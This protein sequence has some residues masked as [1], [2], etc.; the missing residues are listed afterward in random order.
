M[1]RLLVVSIV[2]TTLTGTS[3]GYAQVPERMTYQGV[4]SDAAGE[5][6]SMSMPMT[7]RIYGQA[8]GG[9]PLWAETVDVEVA[10]GLFAAELG[11]TTP[12]PAGIF[13]ADG[14]R[15]LGLEID[16]DGEMVPR[17][18]LDSVPYALHAAAADKVT[19]GTADVTSVSVS[20]VPVI[21]TQGNWVGPI[22][23]LG[24]Q[25]K[26][27]GCATGQAAAYD[28]HAW[29]CAA[30]GGGAPLW[31]D[32]IGK[33]T[34]LGDLTCAADGDIATWNSAIADWECVPVPLS[35]LDLA[36]HTGTLG[37]AHGGT[38]L[39]SG[40]AGGLVYF[41]NSSTMAA[42]AA[43]TA[44]ALLLGAGAGAGPTVLP[45]GAANY[46]VGMNS[47]GTQN[48]YKQLG[49]QNGIS[50][51]NAAGSIT[52][53]IS[54]G[55]ITAA[56]IADGTITAAKMSDGAGSGLDADMVD[57]LHAAAFAQ[58]AG[59][60]T[61]TG[62]NTFS[63]QLTSSVV[64]GTAPF[65]IASTTVVS[66]LNADQLDGQ[67]GSYYTDLAQHTGTLAVGHGG[68]GLASGTSGGVPYFS[69]TATMASSAALAANAVVVGGGAGAAPA[70]LA[71]GGSNYVLGTNAGNNASEYK[72]VIAGTG[73]SV[74]HA[75]GSI[76]IAATGGGA[77]PSR[78]MVGTW[79]VTNLNANQTSQQLQFP[80]G[81]GL[82]SL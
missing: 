6:V 11:A 65:S 30:T 29:G 76:T 41:S 24:P 27:L 43:L 54:T 74:T 14:S 37:V 73:I 33:P 71:F 35:T 16:N 63:Q 62:T 49:G 79:A 46:L 18:A 40:A 47:G 36:Q 2:L 38:G 39:T 60:Q 22:S 50:I 17:Q 45:L 66:N 80:L 53:G 61:L 9:S 52:I 21:D 48:E 13:P 3:L 64:T 34:V 19:G 67:H 28:G 32:I 44:K 12:L 69:T 78:T 70:T 20:G 10:G 77:V 23:W 59:N 82:G 55:S 5:L 1:S 72:Q 75:A 56:S 51:A 15:W 68:S 31:S 42:T 25:L 26:D 57:G 58:V 4:L 8:Q 81:A 7:F